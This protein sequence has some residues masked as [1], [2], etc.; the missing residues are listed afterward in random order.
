MDP[1]GFLV[2]VFPKNRG[3]PKW[4][5][6]NGKPENPIKMDDLGVPFIIFI[7]GNILDNGKKC[8]LEFMERHVLS[9]HP[10]YKLMGYD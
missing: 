8:I 6:Y 4:M 3:T 5:V 10:F 7:F 2:W 1:M 9:R